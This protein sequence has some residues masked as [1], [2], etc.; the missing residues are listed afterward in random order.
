[1]EFVLLK[2]SL[3]PDLNTLSDW[4]YLCW[5]KNNWLKV[6]HP[7]S[8]LSQCYISLLSGIWLR[9]WDQ[10]RN[11]NM[12]NKDDLV[13]QLT[14]PPSLPPPRIHRVFCGIFK[15]RTNHFTAFFKF[16]LRNFWCSITIQFN[17]FGCK[18]DQKQL[19]ILNRF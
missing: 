3:F 8:S 16:G 18:N 7:P 15:F 4:Q 6:T 2:F 10:H 12:N 11:T 19:S 5:C 9:I 1:M 14:T 17:F 13:G